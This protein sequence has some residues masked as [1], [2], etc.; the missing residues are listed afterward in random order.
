MD[1][2]SPIAVVGVS[3]LFPGAH[4]PA[5]FWNLMTSGRSAAAEVPR[6]RWNVSPERFVVARPTPDRAYSRVCCLLQEPPFD[7][8]AFGPGLPDG[9]DLDPMQRILLHAA[10]GLLAGPGPLQLNRER[11]AVVLAAIVLPTDSATRWSWEVFAPRIEH[12][13][14][15]AFFRRP[16]SAAP[17]PPAAARV[18]SFPAALLARAFGLGG[19]SFTLDA[20]CASSLYAVKLACD[21]LRAGRADAVVTGG[22]SRPDALFTQIGFS[23]LRALSPSGRCAPFDRHA[24]GLVV[25]EGVGLLLLKRL[26][27]ALQAGDRI[28]GVIRGIGLSNDMRGS[29]LA[30]DPEGQW[31]ALAAAYVQ[32]GWR[33]EE[34]DYIE[35]HGAGTPVGD[36]VELESLTRLRGNAPSCPIGSVK[37]IIGHLLT[38]A[39]AAG[40]IR[41]LLAMHHGLIPPTL[42]FREPPPDSPIARGRFRIPGEPEP[43]T[44]RGPAI[45]RRAAVSAFGFGGING[46]LLLE[47]WLAAR[48]R[49][50]R[51]FPGGSRGPT[52]PGGQE[53]PPS[54]AS[55]ASPPVAV[56]GLA[57]RVGA[58]AS[59]EAL[60]R[61]FENG[62]PRLLSPPP[63]ER[64][65]KS[66]PFVPPEAFPA[67]LYIAGEPAV[68][69]RFRIPPAEQRDLLRQH[70]LMLEVA[71]AALDD[72]GLDP[73]A[74]RPAMGALVGIDFDFEATRYG[75]RWRLEDLSAVRSPDETA[76][77]PENVS[78]PLTASRVLGSLGSMVASRIA[79]EFRLGGPSYAVSAE[80]CSG[81]RALEIGLRALQSGEMEAVLVGA[82]DLAGDPRRLAAKDGP[83][84]P[85]AEGA[86]AL[87]L[88]RWDRA[89]ADGDRIRLVLRGAGAAGGAE[90]GSSLRR[91]FVA[92]LAE[93]QVSST[94]VRRAVCGDPDRGGHLRR[95]LPEGTRIESA[96]DRLGDGGA[97]GGLLALLQAACFAAVDPPGEG[98]TLISAASSE[99]H[100]LQVLAEFPSPLETRSGRAAKPA[101]PGKRPSDE[102]A[103]TPSPATPSRL[104]ASAARSAA[105]TIAAL[106]GS[107]AAAHRKY[108]DFSLET[109]RSLAETLARGS[110]RREIPGASSSSR[111]LFD[112]A[113][114]L[115]FARGSAARVL[116]PEFAA[117]DRYRVRVRLPDEPLMLVDRI[118]EIEGRKGGL[119]PGR[120]V[121]EHDVRENAWYLDGGRAPVSIAVEA[122]QADLFLCAWLGIDL[123]VRGRRAY[124]LLDAAVRFHRALPVPGE[125]IRYAIEI[126]K[127]IRQGETHLFFFRFEGTIDGR[128]LIT[129]RGGCAG[130]FTA[131]ESLHSGGIVLSA[132]EMAPAPGKTPA[133][134]SWPLPEQAAAFDDAALEALREG[135]AA[136]AF[137]PLFAGVR[138]PETLRLPGG[139]LRLIDRIVSFEPHGGRYGLGLIRAEADI[140]PE[141]WYLVCHFVDDRV[142]P[143]TLMYECCNQALRVL[144]LRRGWFLERPGLRFEPVP[145][146]EAVLTCR[147]P[148]TP[149]VRRVHAEVHLREAGSRPEPYVRADAF[150]YADG[151]R[152]VRFRDLSLQLCGASAADLEAFW[153]PRKIPSALHRREIRVSRR[154]LEDFAT[155]RS[156]KALGDP[157]LPYDGN[158]H[159]ARLPGPPFLFLDR[160]LEAGPRPFVLRPGGW[161]EAEFDIRP[162]AW[163]VAAER[164]GAPPF[165][166]L[167]E[168][169]LQTCGF[170]AAFLGSA[171]K[172]EKDLFFRNLD[173][174]G[175]LDRPLPTQAETLR[176]RCR[177]TR[178][179]EMADLILEQFAF[180]VHDRRGL[181]YSGTAGFGFFTREALD[182]QRGIAGAPA[183]PSEETQE[184]ELRGLWPDVPPFEP[185]DAEGA[186]EGGLQLPARALRMIDRLAVWKPRGGRASA[187]CLLGVKEVRAEEWFFQAH[188]H[189]DPVW[190]GSL[191]LEALI[192]L[193]K[194]AAIL[195]MPER[196]PTHRFCLPPGRRHRWSYRGQVRPQNRRVILEADLQGLDE[197]PGET[198]LWG[199]GHLWVDGLCIY[200]MEGFGVGLV[201]QHSADRRLRPSR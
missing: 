190:P 149:A 83:V 37:S 143:G 88:K 118:L 74:E 39:G 155:G 1:G 197:R 4:D 84:P 162:E 187:G 112:R 102:T 137:G 158:R 78:P 156:S 196:R 165:C 86:V 41:V 54:N 80:A 200:R 46:H 87:V 128:P 150:L 129:M 119:G 23:Q 105:E 186:P 20:A 113:A 31:R 77:L 50:P 180:E 22:V 57:V 44:R 48:P 5:G 51:S 100:C 195:K 63:R 55:A 62:D 36:A 9:K 108:L 13:L 2:P 104:S 71:A 98:L 101:T 117:V 194:A 14:D 69:P 182:G 15:R 53:P 140:D 3:G 72:A 146:V 201:P 141:A 79:R 60:A 16:E 148:V 130:F 125:T 124:R 167:L 132:E 70:A 126:E 90:E 7:P 21:A 121:T 185:M 164:T 122:G 191:G 114:C 110:W 65:E 66:A 81:L 138:I 198:V 35:C 134:F 59:L 96:A 127:F 192:Q 28:W 17:L 68:N 52:T 43:W 170:L 171:L 40:M 67:G 18:A 106:S 139:R 6:E 58:Y 175:M 199:D 56:I 95:L 111:V 11:T 76:L 152:I 49:S 183:A 45:P 24:D 120:I 163:Y 89:V 147:G 75:L 123:A 133:S 184:E 99:G 166:V 157:Y 189:G 25:G 91:A 26:E 107:T 115:E 160:I 34:V 116:G 144:L 188:F 174:S 151:R 10:H 176:T 177:L 38:A 73:Q 85:P 8:H 64:L 27:D 181:L 135:D 154:G 82:V 42:N 30:P 159:L 29:L 161:A 12:R 173:G 179:S 193:L 92:A 142:M 136:R 168:T 169:A 32:A 109:T 93:A 61:V 19:G 145:G 94:A 47:E 131:E 103:S 33:P 172:S 153:K 178:V 97:A